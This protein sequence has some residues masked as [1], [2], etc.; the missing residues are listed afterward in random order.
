MLGAVPSDTVHG[1]LGP[2]PRRGGPDALVFLHGLG[3]SR[4][5]F[6]PGFE[7]KRL[8]GFTLASVDFPGF[9]ESPPIQGFSYAMEDLA[10]GVASRP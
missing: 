9:G 6:D 4:D 2:T 7:R 5:S 3:A 8:A 1:T 10:D